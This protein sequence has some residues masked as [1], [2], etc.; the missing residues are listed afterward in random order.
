MLAPAYNEEE[1]LGRYVGAVVAVLQPGWELL[2]IDDGSADNTGD[3]ADRLA[4]THP[5]VRVVH[6]P[7]NRGLGA[8]LAT[9]FAEAA[10]DVIVAMDADLSHSPAQIPELVTACAMADAAFASRFVPGGAME[11]V[12]A[13]RRW[14]SRIGNLA[15]RL[16]F[17]SPVHDMTTG[18]RAYQA[19]V[20]R[21]LTITSSG[22]EAQ[23]EVAVRL[24]QRR[25]RIVEVP[26]RLRTRAAGM[27]KM[28]YLSLL[29]DYARAVLRLLRVRW[30]RA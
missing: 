5:Q 14:I 21:A 22:F 2:V 4:A 28:R 20:A 13:L 19:D 23:L 26:L 7:H 3:I 27:S 24:I 9:G 30:G 17:W 12:P 10:G 6:H 11:G 1:V 25:A 18:F 8:A 29:P 15:F 16:V